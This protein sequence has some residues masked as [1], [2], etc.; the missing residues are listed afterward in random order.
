MNLK[1]KAIQQHVKTKPSRRSEEVDDI[2]D[3]MPMAFG[4]WVAIAVV[5]FAMLFLLFGW[6]I[7]YPDMVTG[8]IRINARNPAVRL[9]ANTSGNLHLFSRKPQEDVYKGEYIAVLKNPA[10]TKDIQ[11]VAKLIRNIESNSVSLFDLKETFPDKVS[12]G[13][14]SVQYYSFLSALKAMSDYIRANL[15]EKQKESISADIKWKKKIAHEAERSLE[16]SKQRL[17]ITRKW[18][19]RDVTLN[20][21]NKLISEFESDQSRNIYLTGQ[22]EIQNINK[23]ITSTRMQIAENYSRLEQLELEQKEKERNL[24]VDVLST[25]QS[26]KAN[27]LAWEQKYA[28][29]A[30]FDGKVEFLKFLSDGQFIQAGEE[31]FGIVPK[32]NHIYGQMLL[33]ANGAGKVK[34]KGKVAIKLEN[35]PYM[36]YGYIEGYVSSISLV[37][38]PQKIMENSVD[39]YLIDVEL[40]HGL[41]TNYGETLTF[42]YEIGGTADII[43]KER[44]LIERLFDNLR[45][46]THQ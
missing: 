21:E 46:R 42:K 41:T 25:F 38:Q 22:Q 6:I 34:I 15:Y 10:Y 17:D 13:E 5:F 8:Q 39:T 45:Y 19:T 27:I 16:T 2:I 9:V 44:R 20:S 3:R 35:Y 23:E 37:S 26:L 24:Q 32:K 36:E 40:P 14:V 7:K 43:V 18:F 4:R 30:P 33:P 31:V 28:L 29:I 11:K 1:Q 12:L